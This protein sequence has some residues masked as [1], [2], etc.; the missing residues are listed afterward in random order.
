MFKLKYH[1]MDYKCDN[2]TID[3]LWVH[4]QHLPQKTKKNYNIGK[5][6]FGKAQNSVL[7]H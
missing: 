7:L 6:G 2:L 3:I 4:L 1:V 5:N